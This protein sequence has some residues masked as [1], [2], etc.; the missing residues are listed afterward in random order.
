MEQPLVYE[1]DGSIVFL[2][3]A[4]AGITSYFSL[5]LTSRTS[6]IR[7]FKRFGYSIGSAIPISVGTWLI[8]FIGLFVDT[9]SIPVDYHLQTTLLSIVP[10]WCG[11][12]LA[13]FLVGRSRQS[14]L[15]LFMGS[16]LVGLGISTM[17]CVNTAAIQSSLVL[18]RCNLL[19]LG[20]STAI[21]SAASFVAF[22]IAFYLQGETL[23]F[24]KW[25]NLGST[26]LL[27]A[28]IPTTHYLGIAAVYVLPVNTEAPFS[29]LTK[30]NL[31]ITGV[32]GLGTVLIISLTLLLSFFDK[33]FLA[34]TVYTQALQDSQET[35]QTILHGVR[36]GVLVIESE[37]EIWLANHAV[38]ELLEL[39]EEQLHEEWQTCL[40]AVSTSPSQT[41]EGCHPVLQAIAQ[42]RTLLNA[43]IECSSSSKVGQRWLLVNAIPQCSIDGKHQQFICTFCDVTDL[44][45]VEQALQKSEAENRAL[46]QLAEAKS[47]QLSQTL[48]ELKQA[49]SKIVHQE[50]MSSL[51]QMVAGIA[52]EINNPVTF[53]YGNID[54]VNQYTHDLLDLV[55]AFRKQPGAIAPEIYNKLQVL[56][57]DFISEDLPRLFKSMKL[58]AERIREIVSSLRN[59]SRL[60]EAAVKA[61][62]LHEGIDS[63]LMILGH[64]LK[65]SRHK[66]PIQ[67]VKEYGNLPLI[68]CH[69]G[70]MNQVFM[71]ILS[72]AIDALDHLRNLGQSTART[73]DVLADR[74]PTIQ[75][76]TELT[77]SDRVR[78]CIS[79][80]GLGIPCAVRQKIFDPFYTTKP[81]GQGT[82]LGLFISYQIV[83]EHHGGSLSCISNPGEGTEVQIE[84]PIA[85]NPPFKVMSSKLFETE[86][87][88]A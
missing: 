5:A 24:L 80:T 31:L 62:N 20:I 29:A 10:I 2:A 74:V 4:I 26:V 37:Q 12:S 30:D 25:R 77:D 11:N 66:A 49:Q 56:D 55:Q 27:G 87:Q 53:I 50:K 68:E 21:T 58:G 73:T 86:L 16:V 76:R 48:H 8:H 41:S 39:T 79:D 3:I 40:T 61:V 36:V 45:L 78:V 17:Q 82:G 33:R 13:L 44:K 52:H 84:I 9:Y 75:I 35:L 51:G 81:V 54:Y 23:P 43:V 85:Q 1:Y 18:L 70:Q 28:V 15:K 32:V 72:N 69:A 67:V 19:T 46:A 22:F 65:A 83:V 34:Q 57:F 88:R 64:K 60:D 7:G 63:T 6:E 71:N 42:H 47:Q 59:F 14:M 38:L